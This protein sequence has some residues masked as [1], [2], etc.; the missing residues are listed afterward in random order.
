[1]PDNDCQ[2]CSQC[3]NVFYGKNQFC[4]ECFR[5]LMEAND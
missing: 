5:K 4:A 3:A 1:M 2:T